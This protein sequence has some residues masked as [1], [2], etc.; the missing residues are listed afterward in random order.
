MACALALA[1]ADRLSSPIDNHSNDNNLEDGPGEEAGDAQEVASLVGTRARARV[2]LFCFI[3]VIFLQR[4]VI[5]L[6]VRLGPITCALHVH[7]IFIHMYAQ[8]SAGCCDGNE[9]IRLPG[10]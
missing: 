2:I 1:L 10:S 6:S 7:N 3:S 8:R 4:R 9:E 5:I